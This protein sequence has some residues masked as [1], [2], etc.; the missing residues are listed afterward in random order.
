M[1]VSRLIAIP[2]A[3]ALTGA[4]LTAG[5]AYADDYPY[6]GV[7]EID[8]QH[9]FD[10]LWERLEGAVEANEMVVVTRASASRG[11]AGR[12][13]DIPGNAVF[14]VYRNDFAVRMLDASVPAGIEAPLRIYLTEEPDGT[15]RLTYREPSAVF[16][17]YGSVALDEMAAELDAIF[18]EI[19]ADATAAE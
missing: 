10:T 6:E 18:A 15:T 12:G 4:V 2:A 19:V 7:V 14:G 3:F 8:T 1:T 5:S 17:P 9:D 13:V 16:A 11:A